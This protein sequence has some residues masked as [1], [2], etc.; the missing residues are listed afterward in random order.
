MVLTTSLPQQLSLLTASPANMT[1]FNQGDHCIVPIG[2]V[3]G[4]LKGFSKDL[5]NVVNVWFSRS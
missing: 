2:N 4:N 5:N 1:A 3:S